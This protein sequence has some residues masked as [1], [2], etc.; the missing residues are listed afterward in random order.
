MD[1][2]K[3]TYIRSHVLDCCLFFIWPLSISNSTVLRNIPKSFFSKPTL[4]KVETKL[5]EVPITKWQ[6]INSSTKK[7]TLIRVPINSDQC[8]GSTHSVRNGF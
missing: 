7:R 5:Y 4:T 1:M 3:N 8:W 2:V 6:P